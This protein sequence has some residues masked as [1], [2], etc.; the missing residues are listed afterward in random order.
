MVLVRP[1]DSVKCIGHANGSNQSSRTVTCP[2]IDLTQQ[3]RFC[4]NPNNVFGYGILRQEFK[5]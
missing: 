1:F 3:E 2:S 4:F 5:V